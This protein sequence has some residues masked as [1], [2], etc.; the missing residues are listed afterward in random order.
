[1]SFFMGSAVWRG[2]VFR[3]VAVALAIGS[4]SDGRTSRI[5]YAQ[6]VTDPTVVKARAAMN[7]GQYGE[8]EALLKPLAR[9]HS[10]SASSTT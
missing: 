6:G 8:A 2:A 3:L 9:R 7:R 5:A 10:N 4:V 1:M